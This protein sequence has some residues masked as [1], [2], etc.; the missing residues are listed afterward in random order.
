MKL[1]L[2]TDVLLLITVLSDM[3]VFIFPS[4]GVTYHIEYAMIGLKYLTL[5]TNSLESTT[6]PYIILFY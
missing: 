4:L 6:L 1:I 3:I 2:F 5:E